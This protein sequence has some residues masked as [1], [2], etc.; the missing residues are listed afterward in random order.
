M[1]PGS[2]ATATLFANVAPAAFNA[3]AVVGAVASSNDVYAFYNSGFL[4]LN[5]SNGNLLRDAPLRKFPAKANLDVSAAAASNSATTGALSVILT[6]AMGR[7][8]YLQPLI[9]LAENA[10]FNVTIPALR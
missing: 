8:Y 10:S 6:Q 7:P 2:I 9:T 4:E 3:V 1:L 5:V